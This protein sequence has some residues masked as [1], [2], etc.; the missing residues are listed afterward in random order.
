MPITPFLVGLRF[1]DD[2]LKFLVD[3]RADLWDTG[4]AQGVSFTTPAAGCAQAAGMPGQGII[5]RG[6]RCPMKNGAQTKLYKNAPRPL[7][8][9]V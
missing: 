1:F 3:Q 5:W 6:E 9:V 2:A 8:Q 4:F 7:R